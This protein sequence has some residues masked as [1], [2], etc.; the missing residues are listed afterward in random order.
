MKGIARIMLANLGPTSLV[1][2]DIKANTNSFFYFLNKNNLCYI[3][4]DSL[5]TVKSGLE[6]KHT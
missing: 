1:F 3:T 5:H 6:A 2:W 4:K